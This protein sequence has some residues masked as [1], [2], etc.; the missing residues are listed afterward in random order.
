MPRITM[1]SASQRGR[2]PLR[3]PG[4]LFTGTGAACLAAGCNDEAN[5][6]QWADV[7]QWLYWSMRTLCLA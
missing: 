3:L 5:P 2:G 4:L 6:S 7:S 1:I